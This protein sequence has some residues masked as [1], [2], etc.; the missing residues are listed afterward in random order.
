MQG[1][2]YSKYP[3]TFCFRQERLHYRFQPP[4]HFWH[5]NYPTIA[6]LQAI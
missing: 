2:I 5:P 3:L 4:Y 6:V 1:W